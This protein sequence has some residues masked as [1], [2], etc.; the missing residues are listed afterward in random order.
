MAMGAF[1]RASWPSRSSVN[2][3]LGIDRVAGT[4]YDAVKLTMDIDEGNERY[5]GLDMLPECLRRCKNC[6]AVFELAEFLLIEHA[7]EKGDGLVS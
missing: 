1:S 3:G 2:V 5:R 4:E 6:G 7:G